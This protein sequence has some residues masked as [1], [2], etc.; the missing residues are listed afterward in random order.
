MSRL[1]LSAWW[2]FEKFER[3]AIMA[4]KPTKPATTPNDDDEPDL[5]S[6]LGGLK[7]AGKKTKKPDYEILTGFEKN[8]DEL[9]DLKDKMEELEATYKAKQLILLE[10]GRSHNKKRKVTGTVGFAGTTEDKKMLY[11]PTTK[12]TAIL[13]VDEDGN[14]SELVN[15]IRKLVP[16]EKFPRWF[17]TA[18]NITVNTDDQKELAR[19]IDYNIKG[20]F[21][22]ILI[23][24]QLINASIDWHNEKLSSGLKQDTIDFI[25]GIFKPV[26]QIK[27]GK[28]KKGE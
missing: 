3:G 25:E 18:I 17:V 4:K 7:Q 15:A 26:E 13:L 24:K 20:G 6:L 12:T 27:Q 19:F 23:V 16:K 9:I 28:K 22:K 10:A 21:D 8:V 1:D 5:K 2:R 14:E 11:V